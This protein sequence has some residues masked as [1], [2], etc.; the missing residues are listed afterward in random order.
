[1]LTKINDVH[2]MKR[3]SAALLEEQ[4]KKRNQKMI[5]EAAYYLAQKRGFSC[6]CEMDDWLQAE[7]EIRHTYN[8]RT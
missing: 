5:A 3:T 1:M 2:V 4:E 6:G 8:Q 7:K